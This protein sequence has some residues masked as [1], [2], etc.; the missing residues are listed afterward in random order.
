M[1]IMKHEIN[2]NGGVRDSPH[3]LLW[4]TLAKLELVV[5][6]ALLIACLFVSCSLFIAVVLFEIICVLANIDLRIV[7]WDC[8]QRP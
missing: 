5:C 3:H 1:F 4:R 8:P 2:N 7:I 6:V